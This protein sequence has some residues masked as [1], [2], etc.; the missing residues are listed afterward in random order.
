MK[1]PQRTCGKISH[2]FIMALLHNH[3]I[4][5]GKFKITEV[6][7]QHVTFRDGQN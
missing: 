3:T 4:L 1:L 6:S 5:E 2:G 7:V